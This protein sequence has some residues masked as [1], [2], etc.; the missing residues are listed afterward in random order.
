MRRL[1]DLDLWKNL[2]PRYNVAPTQDVW[3]IRRVENDREALTMRWGLIPVWAQDT[4][5]G[6]MTINARSETAAEKPSFREAFAKRRCIVPADGFYE[7]D[8][9]TNPRQPYR[10]LRED[11]EPM[12]LAGLWETNERLG[13]TSFTIMTTRANDHMEAIGHDRSPVILEPE[14][15]ATWLDPT[16]PGAALQ[17]LCLPFPD[18]KLTRYPVST[19]VNSVRN[20]EPAC[21]EPTEGPDQ[22]SF[23]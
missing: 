23:L 11:G 8:K 22:F 14:Q 19:R 2:P 4:K 9:M 1:F 3:I 16:T 17:Q 7:W 5:I 21:I 6:A 13:L 15:V 12:A 18:E 10:F 20:D